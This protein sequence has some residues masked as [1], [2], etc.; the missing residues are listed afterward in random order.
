LPSVVA[1]LR[2]SAPGLEVTIDVA[3]AGTPVAA[4]ESGQVDIAL[5][6]TARCDHKQ[7]IERPLFSDEVV[8]VMAKDHPLA[9]KKTIT[10]TD[11][12]QHTLLTS[13]NTPPPEHAWF[14]RTVFGRRKP[15][16]SYERLPLTEAILDVARAGMGVA[17][18]SEWMAGPHLGKGDLVVRRLD[19]GELRRPWR[20]AYRAD[21][22]E[23]ALRLLAILRTAAPRLHAAG[24]RGVIAR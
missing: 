4:L 23:H 14:M 10:R 5:L 15:R 9:A 17:I 24:P 11:L 18:L 20:F 3:H 13:S 19:T 16:L 2:G 12:S 6:T 1:A 22:D 21:L 7:I 8:F